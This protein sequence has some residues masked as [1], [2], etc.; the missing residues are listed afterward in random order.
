MPTADSDSSGRCSTATRRRFVSRG[1]I[2]ED[3]KN[4]GGQARARAHTHGLGRRRRRGGKRR[5]GDL[6]SLS[7]LAVNLLGLGWGH[8]VISCCSSCWEKRDCLCVVKWAV[9]ALR[10]VKKAK[11]WT[12]AALQP[13]RHDCHHFIL[14]KT[15]RDVIR[16]RQAPFCF[17]K[18]AQA[19]PRELR[20]R[21]EL[22]LAPRTGM[23]TGLAIGRRIV[24]WLVLGIFW[25]L[26]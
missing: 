5:S 13:L 12:V 20:V 1:I 23:V 22:R 16:T 6:V 10:E 8:V 24:S 26:G 3:R 9:M 7:G 2:S 19:A 11:S 4:T 14:A 18:L 21:Y 17:P 25:H 15:A